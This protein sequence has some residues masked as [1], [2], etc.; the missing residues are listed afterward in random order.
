MRTNKNTSTRTSKWLIHPSGSSAYASTARSSPA[1]FP[2]AYHNNNDGSQNVSQS[3]TVKATENLWFWSCGRGAHDKQEEA[4]K[5]FV[6]S[7]VRLE[8]DKKQI[9][10]ICL[11]S[12]ASS[13]RLAIT[14]T[15]FVERH[16]FVFSLLLRGA[17]PVS[18]A[19]SL[20]PLEFLPRAELRII[21]KCWVNPAS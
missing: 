20:V 9:T 18:V 11:P 12:A 10:S 3:L 17:R 21:S 2:I 15:S 5:C 6:V 1:V 8:I 16:S 14:R 4:L 19:S 13:P 7:A